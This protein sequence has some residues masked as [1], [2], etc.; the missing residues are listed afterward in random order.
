[1]LGEQFRLFDDSVYAGD[2]NLYY[3]YARGSGGEDGP[4]EWSPRAEPLHMGT[5]AAA[6]DRELQTDSGPGTVH[7]FRIRGEMG[8]TRE[9][10]VHDSVANAVA[11]KNDHYNRSALEQLNGFAPDG[12]FGGVAGRMQIAGMRTRLWGRGQYYKNA[13]EDAGSISAVVQHPPTDVEHMGSVGFTPPPSRRWQGGSQDALP[14]MK[15]DLDVIFDEG[16]DGL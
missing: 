14:G 3:H 5:P 6:M 15:D 1:M 13:T 16:F 8:N 7:A 12:Q 2:S 10:P 11:G 9:D 4:A